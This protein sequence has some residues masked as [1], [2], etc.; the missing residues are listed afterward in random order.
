MSFAR[1]HRDEIP[2]AQKTPSHHVLA[3]ANKLRHPSDILAGRET[4]LNLDFL[5]QLQ[6]VPTGGLQAT[7][8]QFD[9]ITQI[10][11]GNVRGAR[12]AA[13]SHVAPARTSKSL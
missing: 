9:E 12:R 8:C 11:S 3:A 2:V 13:P 6:N 4:E 7:A 5:K 10:G 1:I